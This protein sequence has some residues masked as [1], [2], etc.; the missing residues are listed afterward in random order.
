MSQQD[1]FRAILGILNE[2]LK[3][4]L[5]GVPKGSILE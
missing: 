5:H 1:I 4:Q 3:L 2:D